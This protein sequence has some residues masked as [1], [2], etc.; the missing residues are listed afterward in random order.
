MSGR[1]ILIAFRKNIRAKDG[2][3][4]ATTPASRKGKDCLFPRR[5][6]S[7]ILTGDNH[8]SHETGSKRR[9][10][11]LEHMGRPDVPVPGPQVPAGDDKIGINIGRETHGHPS[12][13]HY[14]ASGEVISPCIALAAAVAT[15]PR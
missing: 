15:E 10:E 2:A 5:A 14:P 4:T 12:A 6:T 13:L 8:G 7:E 9:I 1:P 11:I 3:M